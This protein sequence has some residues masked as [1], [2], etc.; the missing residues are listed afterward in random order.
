MASDPV[1]V[2]NGNSHSDERSDP[3]IMVIFG[4][5]G[6]LTKRKLIPALYNLAKSDLLSRQFAVIGIARS[7]MTDEQFREKI[8]NDMKEFATSEIEP[9]L[10]DWIQRRLHYIAGS[11]DDDGMYQKLKERLEQVNQ[12]HAMPITA[13][14]RDN[15]SVLARL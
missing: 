3:C 9:D 14:C 13:N 12:E 5:S 6:D 4:A 10:W 2:M 8:S 1:N 15:K 7:E 11:F